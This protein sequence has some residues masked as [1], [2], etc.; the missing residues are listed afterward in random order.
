MNHRPPLGVAPFVAP[1]LLPQRR[2]ECR[3]SQ[4][5]LALFL[6]ALLTLPLHAQTPTLTARDRFGRET[7]LELDQVSVEI[8]LLGDLAETIF[9]LQFRNDGPRDLE[10]ELAMPLPEGATVSTYALEVQGA[11]RDAVAV[12]KERA[13]F[14]YESI[15]RQQIDPG[16]VEREAGNIYRTKVYP[17]PRRGTKRLRIGYVEHIPREGGDLRYSLPLDF[18]AE[19]TTF[20]LRIRGTPVEKIRIFDAAGLALERDES[21]TLSSKEGKPEEKSRLDLAIGTDDRPFMVVGDGPQPAFYLSDRFPAIETRPRPK[22]K[23]VLLFWDASESG[24][25]RDHAREFDLLDRWLAE[26]RDVEIDLRLLRNE[27]GEAGIFPVRDGDWSRLRKHLEA[28]VYDGSSSLD[29]VTSKHSDANLVMLFSDGVSTT[30]KGIG[31]LNKPLLFIHSGAQPNEQGILDTVRRTAGTIVHLDHD[32]PEDA[33]RTLLDAP[34]QIVRIDSPQVESTIHDLRFH[35]GQRVRIVGRL[36]NRR[37]G[38]LEI[39]YGVGSEVM[40]RRTVEWSPRSNTNGLVRRAWAQRRLLQL[41]QAETP[42]PSAIIE[43]CKR[44]ALVSD[45]TSLIVLERFSDHVRYEIPPPEANLLKRYHEALAKKRNPA[46]RIGSLP[47]ISAGRFLLERAWRAKLG[48][49][50][51]NFPWHE[52]DLLPRMRQ[53]GIWKHA[54]HVAFQPDQLDAK[55]VSKFTAW[56]DEVAAL[57][58]RKFQLRTH[59]EFEAWRKE[60]DSLRERGRDLSIAK[61]GAP[62]PDKRIAISVRGLVENPDTYTA[63]SDITLGRAIDLAGGPLASGSLADVALYRNAGKVV[64]NTLSKRFTDVPLLPGDMLVVEEPRGSSWHG[65]IDPFAPATDPPDPREMPPIRQQSDVWALPPRAPDF[66]SGLEPDDPLPDTRAAG[67]IRLIDPTDAAMPQLDSFRKQLEAGEDPAAAYQKLKQGHRYPLRFYIEAARILFEHKH[68]DLGARVLSTLIE[69][70]NGSP[71]SLHALALWFAEFQQW[72]KALRTLTSIPPGKSAAHPIA[73]DL[74]SIYLAEGRPRDAAD[75]LSSFLAPKNLPLASSQGAIALTDFNSLAAKLGITHPLGA[76]FSQI[77]PSDIRIVV[78][79]SRAGGLQ[80]EV[81]EP[82]G[83]V[84]TDRYPAS[85]CGGRLKGDGG[86]HE[87]MIR[88]AM[89]GTY[90]IRGFAR[91]PT[92]VRVVV[93]L[94]WGS[95]KA[96]TRTVTRLLDPHNRTK[97]AEIDFKFPDG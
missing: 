9:E 92:T 31:H 20:S 33:L 8:H 32:E 83:D 3:R 17:V 30:R 21:G 56:Y 90:A 1:F 11:L 64:Y 14:A 42:E 67:T 89:P 25:D 39:G 13:R 95:D 53:I 26:I 22:P 48:W 82:R 59:G 70:E 75:T 74:A 88:R 69:R 62:A 78:T 29:R 71:Q 91:H 60:I 52:I 86:I 96:E 36:K 79:S 97:L 55:S 87:Y 76:D 45:H 16:I 54:L 27:A 40:F 19:L 66:R 28:V 65:D 18:P 37:P 51:R 81:V 23:K 63:K 44:H 15:K 80:V 94:R 50:S 12:E 72:E 73:Q 47:R 7:V 46:G 38:Q 10:A 77:L 57:A 58:E 34:L 5:I 4:S 41:E 6:L 68:P 49:Y 93:H 85:P 84:C 61:P 24:H 43:H 35:P 2:Q